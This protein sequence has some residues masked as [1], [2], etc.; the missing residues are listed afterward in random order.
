MKVQELAII[1]IIIILPISIVISAFTQ[2]QIQT[3]NIQTVYDTKLTNAT[4]DAIRAFQIN[5]ANSTMS[6]LANSKIRDIEASV[7]TFKNSM[8]S[9]FGLSGYSEEDLNNYI[10][11][12]VYTM[13]DG[14][15]IY[16]PYTNTE[17]NETMYGLQPYINY[18][19]RYQ[20]GNIDVVIT[21]A[22]DNF[23]T[24]QGTVNGKYVNESGYLIDGITNVTSTNLKYNGVTIEE[25][26]E[27]REY[28]GNAEYPYVKLNGTKYY[29]DNRG[30]SNVNDDYIIYSSNG[31]TTIQ[32]KFKGQ[33][34]YKFYQKY[35]AKNTLGVEYYKDAYTFKNTIKSLG[36]DD[37]EYKDAYEGNTKIWPNDNRKIFDFNNSG[38]ATQ[39]IECEASN[40]NQHRLAIIRNK[41]ETSLS[42]AIANYNTYS[43]ASGIEFLMPQLNEEEWE[44]IQKNISLISFVQGLY[45]GGKTYNGYAI[46]NNSESKEVVKEDDIYILGTNSQ[47]HRINSGY[48]LASLT[49]NI[50]RVS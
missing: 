46:V 12:L 8:M 43:H 32:G 4:Y 5:T 13:Y 7:T 40:F 18:S 36:I 28:F 1:F 6:D 30:T 16:S 50:V 47:Y 9:T 35:I 45:I 42:V 2:F 31:T 49:N 19:C 10:P 41:I 34:A 17:N 29:Y 48:L 23:I 3:L 22:L 33:E 37:L 26:G 14:F 15:Y 44:L 27:L 25:E 38:D 11:A 39:N 20:K 24:V 21:Y